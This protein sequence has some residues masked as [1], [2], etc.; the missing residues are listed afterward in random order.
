MSPMPKSPTILI[1][2]DEATMRLLIKGLLQQ[3]GYRIIEATDGLSTLI[4]AKEK[5][6]DLVVLD[7]YLPGLSGMDVADQLRGWMP[8]LV[9]TVERER[10]SVQACLDR[11]ALGYTPKPP[12]P[13]TF[14]LQVRTALVRGKEILAR[15]QE[16]ANLRRGI[17]E[18]QNIAKALGILMVYFDLSEAAAYQTLSSQAAAERRRALEVAEEIITAWNRISAF[19]RRLG[20]G[21]SMTR[22]VIAA[23]DCL[24]RLHTGQEA[25]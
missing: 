17:Q 9:L 16:I 12:D 7:L 19:Q 3:E 4:L 13:E 11:G 20:R 15:N 5:M 25:R 14:V 1:A 10:D 21:I 23:F 24:N 8:Y 2:E 22:E 6:P 18:T